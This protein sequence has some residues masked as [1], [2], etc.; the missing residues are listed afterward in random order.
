M[1]D[2]CL[3]AQWVIG[4]SFRFTEN[5]TGRRNRFA[6][7]IYEGPPDYHNGRWHVSHIPR[8]RLD[9]DFSARYVILS[10]FFNEEWTA[11]QFE[12]Q[13]FTVWTNVRK[14]NRWWAEIC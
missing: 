12:V 3:P 7:R 11:V 10:I 6:H 4:A 13:G 14:F 8:T 9:V 1:T 5:P 2:R